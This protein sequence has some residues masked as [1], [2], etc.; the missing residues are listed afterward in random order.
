MT[1]HNSST[2]FVE[3]ILTW[4]A[5]VF[6]CADLQAQD[7]NRPAIVDV[8][9]G[10]KAMPDGAKTPNHKVGFWTPVAVRLRGP[11]E[12][13]PQSPE[14]AARASAN[15]ALTAVADDS[16]DCSV[17]SRQMIHLEP[18][19]ERTVVIMVKPGRTR[20]D[21]RISLSNLGG[22]RVADITVQPETGDVG[23]YLYLSLGAKLDG[24][25]EALTSTE[26]KAAEEGKPL[27]K[28]T[29]FAVYDDGR[30]IWG[31]L[32]GVDLAIVNTGDGA[33]VD[34]TL[35]VGMP[36]LLDWV[37]QGGRL[38]IAV[39]PGRAEQIAAMVC[40]K[41][42]AKPAQ[43]RPPFLAKSLAPIE[44]WSGLQNR[45]FP[46]RGET[47]AAIARLVPGDFGFDSWEVLSQLEDKAAGDKPLPLIARATSGFGSITVVAFPLD[48]GA[49]AKWSGQTEFFR[50]LVDQLGPRYV[51]TEPARDSAWGSAKAIGDWGAQLQRDLD[52]FDVPTL[53]FG[54]VA[55]SILGYV[56]LVSLVDY[57]VLRRFFRRL[58]ATWVT[59]PLIVLGVSL[60]ALWTVYS[61]DDRG[62]RVNQIDLYDFDFRTKFSFNEN[63]LW[64][65]TLDR[66]STFFTV[67][68]D[69]IRRFDVTVKATAS[70]SRCRASEP[71]V[72]WFG[73]AD[74]GPAGMGR[75]GAQ[76]LA[77]K[78]YTSTNDA[79][80]LIGV[81]FAFRATKS[82]VA[83]WQ[84]RDFT[85]TFGDGDE[86]EDQ[87]GMTDALRPAFDA[88]LT[89]HPRQSQF[90]VSGTIA[91]QLPFDLEDASL[92][93]FDRVYPIEGGLKKGES[94]RIE[95]REI[96]NGMLPSEW[97]DKPEPGRP[98]T[99]RGV[100]DPGA[101][102]KN[103][104]FHER[105]DPTL[106]VGNHLLRRLD[107]SW[108]LRD[109][110][111]VVNVPLS[112]L[113]VREAI[114]VGRA[115]LRQGDAKTMLDDSAAAV[116]VTLET[117]PEDANVW[118]GRNG[119]LTVDTY[120]RAV[121]PLRPQ[122]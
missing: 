68:G 121:F 7:S 108:R 74:D 60:A 44:A 25:T 90:K 37:Q 15:Y 120:V 24:L 3:L 30:R 94:R 93:V 39:E 92:F 6:A 45:P 36:M 59:L 11:A 104:L 57:F 32:D 34:G 9:V 111:R 81:P 46:A 109:D 61:P 23:D 20:G 38:V 22:E 31:G 75:G 35:K 106:K 29:R 89:Y 2:T 40:P 18:R 114:L 72:S 95:I 110:P 73:R 50:T 54:A 16:E 14:A 97:R 96:D 80:R 12:G 8:Q 117:E 84:P 69:A 113:G 41:Q 63:G 86:T 115:R 70:N 56:L 26:K 122:P 77:E 64:C 119:R 88:N 87:I 17:I 67:R 10:F 79:D 101:A 51:A 28:A 103:I 47:A 49:F 62:V 42:A 105:L 98:V 5:I 99:A 82:F 83:Q 27:A 116:R 58:E 43:S 66:G 71:K 21:V 100:Y 53:S 65:S 33:F 13:K 19:E 91:N 118:P 78:S 52:N 4:L 112:V 107:W 48:A 1:S 85:H 76:S 102:L 55:S